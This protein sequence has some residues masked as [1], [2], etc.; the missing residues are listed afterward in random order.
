M[1]AKLPLTALRTFEAA[2][3]LGGF[4]AAAD[5]LAVTAAAVSHQ[6][7]SLETWLGVQLFHRTGQGVQL[8]EHG[9]QLYRRVHAGLRDIQQSLAAFAPTADPLRLKLTTTA[10]FA[11]A[12]LIPRLGAFHRLHP[13]IQVQVHTGNQVVDLDRDASIDLAIRAWFRPD[14]SL[15]QQPLF[16]EYF[17]AYA[18]PGW[19]LPRAGEPLELID[20]PW[21][22]ARGRPIDWQH[23]SQLAGC[24]GWL[25]RAR[26]HQY[27]DEHYAVQAAIAGHG[28]V[29]ASS[30]LVADSLAR[31]VL[32]PVRDDV[33][34]PAA[35]YC[36]VCVPG[37]ERE[38]AVR[39]F[40]DWLQAAR[41][42]SDVPANHP[43]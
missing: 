42:H 23:W 10:A 39:A 37:R 8:S 12:W 36:A 24:P 41:M 26:R 21:V 18:L 5:E 32:V 25:A 14:P 38:Q 4:K 22:T 30:V 11:S 27:D 1:F 2:A 19:R 15:Y 29:L 33:R 9:E 7:K 35:H 43:G 28:L 16:D 31:G 17:A 13:Q 34:L 3:R 40:L 20:A 6:V